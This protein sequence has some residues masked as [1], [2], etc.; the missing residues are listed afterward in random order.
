MNL[1]IGILGMV[2]ILVAFILDEFYK[3]WNQNTIQ[4]NVFNM[5]G[6]G[7][8]VWYAF[9]SVVWPFVILNVVWFGVAGYKLV[10][11]LRRKRR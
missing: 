1:F 7:L 8:L 10:S 5:I 11:I 2:C 3:K 9:V 4:Y 6:S